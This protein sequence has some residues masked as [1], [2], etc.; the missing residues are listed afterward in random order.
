MTIEFIDPIGVK[1]PDRIL[2]N[3]EN[4]FWWQCIRCDRVRDASDNFC[5]CGAPREWSLPLDG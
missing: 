2:R 3:G 4:P 5:E 1:S